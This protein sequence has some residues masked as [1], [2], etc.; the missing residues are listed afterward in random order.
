M[1]N[2]ENNKLVVY[3]STPDFNLAKVKDLLADKNT[4]T[5]YEEHTNTDFEKI[6]HV[7]EQTFNFRLDATP[8]EIST[9]QVPRI[10]THWKLQNVMTDDT[11]YE[12]SQDQYSHF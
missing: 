7:K 12:D 9:A 2:K 11:V 10:K 3:Q 1:F 6:G 5:L 4:R 8:N